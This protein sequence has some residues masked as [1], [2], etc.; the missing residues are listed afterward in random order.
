VRGF[1]ER[2]M[3]ARPPLDAPHRLRDHSRRGRTWQVPAFAPEATALVGRAADR[4][5]QRFGEF[6]NARRI[7]D[8]IIRVRKG[9]EGRIAIRTTRPAIST[10]AASGASTVRWRGSRSRASSSRVARRQSRVLTA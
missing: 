9:V 1:V 4:A 8:I 3:I 10:S 7:G 5:R 6:E 2:R